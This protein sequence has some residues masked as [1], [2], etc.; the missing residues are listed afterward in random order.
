MAIWLQNPDLH[1]AR[2]YGEEGIGRAFIVTPLRRQVARETLLSTSIGAGMSK[3]F[4]W[5]LTTNTSQ[6]E[7]QLGTFAP[8][9]FPGRR[10]GLR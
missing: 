8:S 7:Q 4:H 6:M 1:A 2:A 10:S 3:A 9:A 5:P